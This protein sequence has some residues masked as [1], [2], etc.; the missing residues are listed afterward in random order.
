MHQSKLFAILIFAVMAQVTSAFSAQ[1]LMTSRNG[2]QI[3]DEVSADSSGGVVEVLGDD[4]AGYKKFLTEIL[5][6]DEQ[7]LK[8][9]QLRERVIYLHRRLDEINRLRSSWGYGRVEDEISMDLMIA[10]LHE[11][12]KVENFKVENCDSYRTNIFISYDPTSSSLGDP[13]E[14]SLKKADQIVKKI[15]N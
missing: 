7:L 10:V 1:I 2:N 3:A 9:S 13:R 8:I 12:P 4:G 15:C 5:V 6:L 14:P 11:I